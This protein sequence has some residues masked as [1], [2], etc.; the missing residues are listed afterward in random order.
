MYS[1][2]GKFVFIAGPCVIEGRDETLFIAEELKKVFESIDADFIFKASFDKA[3]R[4]SVGSYRGPGM[5]EGLK[6]LAEVKEKFNMP[7]LTDVH[8]VSQINGIKEIVDI[9]QIPAF[10]CRQTDLVVA[11]AKTGKC[12][13]LKK[14]Q[15]MAPEDMVYVVEKVKAQGN[16][17]IFLTERGTSFGYGNLV[18]DFR[19]FPI[20]KKTG[21]PVIYDVTH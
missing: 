16:D 18:V 15:F 6:I 20:M 14:A 11:A 2:T 19:A 4:T 13:N 7:V 8:E 21:L 5:D 9:I 12:V 10:L 17:N 3:N 1:F